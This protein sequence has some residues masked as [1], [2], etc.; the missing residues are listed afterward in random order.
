LNPEPLILCIKKQQGRTGL[1]DYPLTM[2]GRIGVIARFG[3]AADLGSSEPF[4]V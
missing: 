1:A 4:I 3:R 2:D